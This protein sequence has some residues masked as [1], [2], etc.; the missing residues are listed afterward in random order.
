MPFGD[1]AAERKRNSFEGM[2]ILSIH[3]MLQTYIFSK[4]NPSGTPALSEWTVLAVHE[5]S[6]V[7]WMSGAQAC[8][9]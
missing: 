1:Y 6:T 2:V 5:L 3:S 8:F 4:K 7:A 9:S